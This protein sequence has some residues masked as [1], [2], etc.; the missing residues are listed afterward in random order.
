LLPIKA[1]CAKRP[2]KDGRDDA[3]NRPYRQCPVNAAVARRA[4]G[5]Y[6]GRTPADR[7][8]K[9]RGRA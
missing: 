2:V 6:L 3:A 4:G 8:A 9:V 7:A 5:S 1:L